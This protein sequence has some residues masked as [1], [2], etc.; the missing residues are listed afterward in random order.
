M[1]K[2]ITGIHCP[3][4]RN[5][6]PFQRSSYCFQQPCVKNL[7][8]HNALAVSHFSAYKYNQSYRTFKAHSLPQGYSFP[9]PVK[10]IVV[11]GILGLT[12]Y[13]AE[14]KQADTKFDINLPVED[15]AKNIAD[16]FFEEII[17]P[18][19]DNKDRLEYFRKYPNALSYILED[20]ESELFKKILEHINP[21]V[22]YVRSLM[23]TDSEKTIKLA[24]EICK[25]TRLNLHFNLFLLA[26]IE[27]HRKLYPTENDQ[28][29]KH[30]Q[31]I[32]RGLNKNF[33]FLTQ[34]TPMERASLLQPSDILEFLKRWENPGFSF[35]RDITQYQAE[36]WNDQVRTLL[37]RNW[38]YLCP[39]NPHESSLITDVVSAFFPAEKVDSG[40]LHRYAIVENAG[41]IL[42][43][44]EM[45][46]T[47]SSELAIL[48]KLFPDLK[49]EVIKKM[50]EARMGYSNLS[51]YI[52]FLLANASQEQL[53]HSLFDLFQ[54]SQKTNLKVYK[55]NL[56][57]SFCRI[58]EQRLQYYPQYAAQQGIKLVAHQKFNRQFGSL[59]KFL[60]KISNLAKGLEKK[61]Y[62]EEQIKAL[63]DGAKYL[64]GWTDVKMYYYD[65]KLDNVDEQILLIKEFLAKMT[66]EGEQNQLKL[67]ENVHVDALDAY[68][69]VLLSHICSAVENTLVIM[70]REDQSVYPC[71]WPSV[72]E[73]TLINLKQFN[74]IDK[75]IQQR[76]SK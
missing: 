50:L 37:L 17:D 76:R 6:Y 23:G 14:S 22:G 21:M 46:Q 1:F 32:Y 75:L 54:E 9:F 65:K 58:V 57:Q 61:A 35:Y 41:A 62:S 36:E 49:T 38:V 68:R 26:I 13:I 7:K 18:L 28:K 71:L 60:N 34:L 67:S 40:M 11:A 69:W 16:S 33:Y 2:I 52:D 51:F 74:L 4:L 63:I 15:L 20:K 25:Q 27:E 8:Q 3:S 72:A 31:T 53:K 43:L 19:E 12:Y 55:A 66:H 5:L 29:I 45:R 30:L 24:Y 44:I 59:S 47:R 10:M 42:A 48:K 56:K 70:R 39:N 64:Q 73:S